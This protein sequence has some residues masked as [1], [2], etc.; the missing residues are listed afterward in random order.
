MAR[1]L[2]SMVQSLVGRVLGSGG[3]LD[4]PL[5][6]HADEAANVLYFGAD[7][8]FSK[9]GG[10]G[11]WLHMLAQSRQDLVAELG[12]ARAAKIL[13]NSEHQDSV[14]G[15]RPGDGRVRLPHGGEEKKVLPRDEPRRRTR[16]QGDGGGRGPARKLH[17]PGAAG[18]LRLHLRRSVQGKD[19]GRG[20]GPANTLSREKK[21]MN[22]EGDGEMNL[23]QAAVSWE[24]VFLSAAA[25]FA[26]GALFS[27][28][29]AR[30][31]RRGGA[32]GAGAE[33]ELRAARDGAAEVPPETLSGLAGRL[34]LAE[35]PAAART[36]PALSDPGPR[37]EPEFGR[38]ETAD[39][40]R[41]EVLPPPRR[42]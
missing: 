25:C 11:V 7:D 28:A 42:A 38:E 14:S 39:F 6:V 8:L 37:P 10:A 27:A 16:R 15:E 35:T 24:T 21:R 9:A 5:A 40:W 22:E 13:D 34:W 30:R 1:V 17:A 20:G 32:T 4:P 29:A 36:A 2:L 33:T 23:P 18:V 3:R 26:L 19:R 12:E 41:E 31:G